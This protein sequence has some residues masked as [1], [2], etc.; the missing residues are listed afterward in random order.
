VL[1]ANIGTFVMLLMFVAIVP[2][3]TF[4]GIFAGYL[5]HKI[6]F[7]V[8]G[9]LVY[10]YLFAT[11]GGSF[12]IQLGNISDHPVITVT[13]VAG[14]LVL[15]GLLV[16]IFFRA[17]KKLWRRAKQGGVILAR[18]RDYFVQ[19]ML[20]QAAGYAAKLAVIGV[21]LAAYGIP[22]TFHSIM[23]VVGSNSLANV[24][25][26]TPGGVGVNQ[27]LNSAS[28][29]SVTD[30][31]TATAYSIAQQLITTAWNIALAIVLVAVFFGWAGGKQLVGTSYVGAK[32]KVADMRTSRKRKK[33]ERT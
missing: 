28:L 32:A 23:S 6:F 2:G 10:V 14:A 33:L 22:V 29:S 17:V 16:R 18:P 5:V 31:S 24:T 4:P 3:A 27:A 1:P 25:S 13:I 12:D 30:A 15:I 19:V 9:A 8:I 11:V 20:P 21:F 26:V 7:T